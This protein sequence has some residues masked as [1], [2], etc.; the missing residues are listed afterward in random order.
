MTYGI[1]RR[2]PDFTTNQ[3]DG[4]PAGRGMGNIE[5]KTTECN[6]PCNLDLSDD[7]YSWTDTKTK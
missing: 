4:E 7:K 2:D 1:M 3:R 5:R 6:I